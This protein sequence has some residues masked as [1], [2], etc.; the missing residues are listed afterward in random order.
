VTAANT[1]Y[2]MKK[3]KFGTEWTYVPLPWLG[4]GGRYDVVEPNLDNSG[5]SFSV[6]SPRIIFR[7]AFVTHEQVMIQYSRY[8]YG[9]DYNPGNPLGGG[10]FP[11]NSQT[12]GAG[13][14]VDKNAAQIAAIIWF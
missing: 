6:I 10:M 4:I 3:L 11:Y 2:T 14:G 13:L 1:A 12:G 9:S 5:Q 7:T 8:F